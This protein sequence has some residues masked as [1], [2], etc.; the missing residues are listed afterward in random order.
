MNPGRGL[1]TQF[2][3]FR[4][5][6]IKVNPSLVMRDEAKTSVS[7]GDSRFLIKNARK[8]EYSVC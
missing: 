8:W 5:F 3:S 2:E 1:L 6:L 4:E 7:E